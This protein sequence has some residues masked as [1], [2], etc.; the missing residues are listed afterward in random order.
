MRFEGK[1]AVVTGAG[2]GIGAAIARRFA[3]EGAAV[4]VLDL[5]EEQGEAVA[6]AIRAAGGQALFLAVD[7]TG[8]ASM[9]D[10]LARIAREF[11]GI[12]ILVNNAVSSVRRPLSELPLDG[13][14]HTLE[15]ALTAA[16]VGAKQGHP[17]M[18][19]RGGGAI[20]NIAS[21]HSHVSYPGFG[22][23]GAAKSGLLG[24][25]RQLAIEFAPQRI[26]VNAVCPGLI[27]TDGNRHLWPPERLQRAVSRF[28]VGRVGQPDDI[29]E[30]TLFLA[31]DAAGYING[32]DLVVDGGLIAQAADVDVYR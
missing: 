12:D 8:E 31:S 27:I 32:T 28:P 4:A 13:W 3:T 18:A 15:I 23:Y 1:V 10:A 11:R 16:F 9:R 29:A 2:Q 22:A 25:T 5:K 17:H 30:A 19:A 6:A 24:L 26:R 21:I 14:R 7:V 20:V